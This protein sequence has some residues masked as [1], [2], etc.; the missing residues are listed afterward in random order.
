MAIAIKYKKII[1]R[2]V[3]NYY[4]SFIKI[5]YVEPLYYGMIYARNGITLYKYIIVVEKYRK[6]FC[7][8]GGRQR[9]SVQE[10]KIT[11]HSDISTQRYVP[12][13]AYY[14][15]MQSQRGRRRK[16]MI[17]DPRK[18]ERFFFLSFI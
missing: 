3:Q 1:F 8:L 13:Y 7:R 4:Q 6:I 14:V 2:D 15:Y 10:I 5:Q 17:F 9:K 11:Y 18:R 16:E 12:I